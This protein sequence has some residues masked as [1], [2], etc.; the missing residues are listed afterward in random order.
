MGRATGAPASASRSSSENS[1][2]SV[3]S[4][5]ALAYW[6]SRVLTTT[7]CPSSKR[8]AANTRR[9]PGSEAWS[10]RYRAWTSRMP[11]TNVLLGRSGKRHRPRPAAPFRGSAS[12]RRVAERESV[13]TRRGQQTQHV[14]RLLVVAIGPLLLLHVPEVLH[15]LG[16][17]VGFGDEC[18]RGER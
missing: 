6:A 3:A 13:A 7:R 8:V 16:A 12:V 15:E 17:A 11:P 14:D 18:A 5:S 9:A 1:C 10:S 4:S 2:R